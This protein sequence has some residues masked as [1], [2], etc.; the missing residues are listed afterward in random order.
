MPKVLINGIDL[1]YD[2]QGN[3]EK[4]P[5][6]LIAGFDSDISTWSAIMPLLVEEYQVI[7]FDNR[8]I[9]QSF[10]PDSPYSIKQMAVDAAALLDELGINFVHVVG[11]SMGGQ[12]AQ[13]LTLAHPEKVQSLIL[14]S[15]WT[16]GDRKFHALIE[17]FG[18]LASKLDSTIYHQKILLPWMFSDAFYS[19]E[20]AIEQ[21]NDLIENNPFPPLPHGLYHQSQAILKSNTSDRLTNI[22]TPTLVVVGKDDLLTPVKFSEQLAT[23][24][25]NAELVVLDGGHAFVVESAGAVAKTVLDFLAKHKQHAL[26]SDQLTTPTVS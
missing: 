3:S 6:L 11:H 20:G 12:I 1:F 10:A 18:D 9:G 15:S 23:G 14:L 25:P 26:Q 16:K 2:I 7:R 19:T 22:C 17:M 8:G 13:E 21:V 4:E 5:L 24:I